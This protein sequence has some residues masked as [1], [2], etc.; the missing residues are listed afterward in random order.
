MMAGLLN[1]FNSLVAG[2]LVQ[3]MMV[4]DL[5]QVNPDYLEEMEISWHIAMVVF[6]AK[7]FTQRT[8]RNNWVNNNGYTKNAERAM[9]AQQFTWENQLQDLNINGDGRAHL[10]QIEGDMDVDA[11]EEQMMDLQFAFTVSANPDT[12][13]ASDDVSEV[14]CSSKSCIHRIARYRELNDNLVWEIFDLENLVHKHKKKLKPLQEK[15]DA[16][17]SDYLKI[18][19]EH[20]IK[21]CHLKFAN[22][23][24]ARLTA[25]L[26]TLKSNFQDNES[27]LKKIYVSSENKSGTTESSEMKSTDPSTSCV[28]KLKLKI[29]DKEDSTD[30]VSDKNCLKTDTCVLS[31]DVKFDI[32]TFDVLKKP[33]DAGFKNSRTKFLVNKSVAC[34]HMTGDMSQLHNIENFNGGCVCF[35]GGEKENITQK[36]TVSNGVLRFENVNFVPEFMH[37][38]VSV[39]QIYD[40]GF[41]THFTKKEC[42]ILKPGKV[43]PEEWILVR[44]ECQN[45]AYIIN[46]SHNTLENVTCLFSKASEQNAMLWHRRLGH[47]NAKNLNRLAK[48]DIVQGLPIKDFITF[49]KCVACAQGKHHQKPYKP[50]MINSIDSLLQLLHMDLL[51]PVNVL[52]INRR[53]SDTTMDKFCTNKGVQRQYS[54]ART[55]Q[56]NG[57]AERRNRCLID[58]ART[59]LCDSKLLVIFWAEAIKTAC[60]AQNR[61]I[62]NKSQMKTPYEIFYGRKPN[63]SYLCTFGCPCTLLHLKATLK[64]N[65]KA[66]DCYFMGYASKT[67]F[68]VYNKVTKQ[69][70]ESYDVRWLEENEMVLKHE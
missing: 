5:N 54:A 67:A 48:N 21:N 11:A 36:G 9:V 64:F 27:S 30:S 46:M 50:K 45:N 32:K 7:R 62:I 70:V 51:G 44:S 17:T 65:S 39:S 2:D 59:L 60:Y 42:L 69:I 49:E 66:D 22:E 33:C 34:L 58:V 6:R 16:K 68:R 26:D 25:E 61:D 55:P 18:Q 4:E 8:G 14:S 10:A 43:I 3:P 12:T 29:D 13:P 28:D 31:D 19:D 24:I 23:D 20:T 37:S 57:V 1:C 35:A 15:L 52:S 38:L 53:R 41:S 47:T 40:K 56:Q 63:V